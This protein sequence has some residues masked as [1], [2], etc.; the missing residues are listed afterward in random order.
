M[1]KQIL[2]EKMLHC[3]RRQ[4]LAALHWCIYKCMIYVQ[5]ECTM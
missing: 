3:K 4:Q 1:N 5:L 2:G